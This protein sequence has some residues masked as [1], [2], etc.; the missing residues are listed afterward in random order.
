MRLVYLTLTAIVCLSIQSYSFPPPNRALTSPPALMAIDTS[1]TPHEVLTK[2]PHDIEVKIGRKLTHKERRTLRRIKKQHKKVK[3]IKHGE[4]QWEELSIVSF[5]LAVAGLIN[6]LLVMALPL[7]PLA[8]IG[9]VIT[10]I[11]LTI[12]GLITGVTA[13]DR[14]QQYPERK[15]KRFAFLGVLLSFGIV[16]MGIVAFF[17]LFA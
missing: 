1:L 3:R 14:H 11:V 9:T 7:H 6:V 17:S 15:G 5:T 12:L 16:V 8:L 10:A 4:A 13:L 2:S